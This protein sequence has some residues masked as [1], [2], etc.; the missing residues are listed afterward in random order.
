MVVSC[1]QNAGQIH[2]LLIA[3][4]SS[5]NVAKLKYLAALSHAIKLF[6]ELHSH[7][8]YINISTHM[9]LSHLYIMTIGLNPTCDID[10]VHIFSL[11]D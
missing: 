5:E 6:R 11:E 7:T 4:K 2:N 8:I 10:F 3:N 1:H 9:A